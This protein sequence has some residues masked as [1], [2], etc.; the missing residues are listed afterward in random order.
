MGACTTNA[1][2]RHYVMHSTAIQA[3]NTISTQA[4]RETE[5]RQGRIPK[6][7]DG[8]CAEGDGHD[9]VLEAR[10]GV[11]VGGDAAALRV[12][13]GRQLVRQRRRQ[14]WVC[15]N[16][17]VCRVRGERNGRQVRVRRAADRWRRVVQVYMHD[18]KRV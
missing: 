18:V 7:N 3:R 11:D 6:V 5:A 14:P 16:V 17:R 15:V 1:Q 9:S 13:V 2:C 12:L 8:V 10:V 4:R